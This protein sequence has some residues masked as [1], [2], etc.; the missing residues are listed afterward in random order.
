MEWRNTIKQ[1]T[2]VSHTVCITLYRRERE[3]GIDR[4]SETLACEASGCCCAG[5][6]AYIQRRPGGVSLSCLASRGKGKSTVSRRL[7]HR[8]YTQQILFLRKT[9]DLCVQLLYKNT[10][11]RKAANRQKNKITPLHIARVPPSAQPLTVS[12]RRPLYSPT[13]QTPYFIFPSYALTLGAGVLATL[14]SASA[15]SSAPSALSPSSLSSLP[16]YG[17]R[18]AER[19]T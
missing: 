14:P 19:R 17:V 18:S 5:V 6:L 8:F 13:K 12:P 2:L 11:H 10:R 15:C 4:E 9:H 1:P 16:A 7:L 3:G